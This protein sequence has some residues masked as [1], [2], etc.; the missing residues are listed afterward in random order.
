MS[1][2]SP[3]L[4][5]DKN[6]LRKSNEFAPHY[7]LINVFPSIYVDG[8]H[9]STY[10]ELSHRG[11]LQSLFYKKRLPEIVD[12]IS[13]ITN[14]PRPALQILIRPLLV[15]LLSLFVDRSIRISHRLYQFPQKNIKVL[16]VL[17]VHEF[18]RLDQFRSLSVQNWQFNQAI[19][20]QIAQSLGVESEIYLRQ[21]EYPEYPFVTPQKNLI[22]GPPQIEGWASHL[23]RLK[24]YLL[25][26]YQRIPS[27]VSCYTS[28]GFAEDDYWLTKKN[29]YG[30]IGIF[31]LQDNFV[32]ENV[33]LN[34]ELRHKLKVGLNTFI[35]NAIKELL[36]EISAGAL[37]M[38]TCER[39]GAFFPKF[40][41]DYVPLHFFEGLKPNLD[42]ALSDGK[43]KKSPHII[44]ADI[45][46]DESYFLA[47]ATKLLGG[48]I[49]GVQHGGHYGYIEKLTAQAE[50]EYAL[51]D[52]MVTWGWKEFEKDLPKT[53]V[54]SLPSPSLSSRKIKNKH[55][56]L[57]YFV[58]PK[59]DVL[60]MTNVLR[61]FAG[62]TTCGSTRVDFT[63]AILDSH[64]LLLKSL[65][66]ADI[67]VDHKPYSQNDVNLIPE[68]FANLA[69]LG[70]DY[71]RLLESKQKGLSHS[72]IKDYRV[73]LWDQI[74]T[75]ALEC[76]VSR[77]PTIIHWERIYSRETAQARPLIA[78]LESVGVVHSSATS[79]AREMSHLLVDP[80]SWMQ[81]ER[82]QAAIARFCNSFARV[83]RRWPALWRKA[84]LSLDERKFDQAVFANA[85]E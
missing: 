55:K 34:H 25:T 58:P 47:A 45:A 5:A 85:G 78:E 40:F 50:F 27:Y 66:K 64:A 72:L 4:V 13:S 77:I 54:L 82:R 67:R 31:S 74:G 3:L 84:L 19:I 73:I 16:K 22:V 28:L 76:F 48:R 57:E 2:I 8:A 14:V 69:R 15:T 24:N 12:F 10:K 37:H 83:D 1:T 61:R 18:D 32:L 81:D 71:Y 65:F 41:T 49:I 62:L 36:F 7:D 9:R 59:S 26:K 46:S 6:F 52:R 56:L 20:Q 42:R 23:A 53:R 43:G 68:H 21:D 80:S 79:L 75:G 11:T 63:G 70:G 39:L 44:G 17:P 29:F 35:P 33:G 51:Y 38:E 30:P 60:F